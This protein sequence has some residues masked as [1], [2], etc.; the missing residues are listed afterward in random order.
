MLVLAIVP[1]K[2]FL[3]RFFSKRKEEAVAEWIQESTDFSA[4]FGDTINPGCGKSN[5][6]I[7]IKK[8]RN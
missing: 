1:V 6:G 4:W 3:I 2:Y 7:F 8:S 5:Y